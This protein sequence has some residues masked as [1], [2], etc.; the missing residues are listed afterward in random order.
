M[1]G[2]AK[3]AL[4]ATMPYIH[5]RKAFGKKIADFQVSESALLWLQR[6]KKKTTTCDQ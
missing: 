6:T 1:L 2:L 5:E 4:D 3:G